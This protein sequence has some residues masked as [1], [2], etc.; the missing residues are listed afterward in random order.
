MKNVKSRVKVTK[1]LLRCGNIG[2]VRGIKKSKESMYSMIKSVNNAQIVAHIR[3]KKRYKILRK[4]KLKEV[5]I[6]IFSNL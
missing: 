4:L 2:A 5:L 3:F 1:A 6:E